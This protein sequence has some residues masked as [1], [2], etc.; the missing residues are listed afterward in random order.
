MTSE[1]TATSDG[2]HKQGQKLSA[3]GV[4]A[5]YSDVLYDGHDLSSR[6]IEMR[7]GT[8]I[9]I[10][11]IRPTLNGALVQDP[12]PVVWMHMT[13]NR[14]HFEGGLTGRTYPGAAMALVKYG[15]VVAIADMRGCYASH[16]HAVTPKRA[17]WQPDAFY[18]AYDITE[19]LAAQPWSTGKIGMWG[20]SATGHS[21]WQAAAS[22]PPH[23]AAIMPLS[24]PS[25]YYD[26]NGVT[27]TEPQDP[28]AYPAAEPPAADAGAVPVDE[29][30]DGA[31]LAQAREAHRWNLEPGVMPFRDSV[32]PWLETLAGRKG[33]QNHLLVNTFTHFPQI[34]ASG[35]P[36]YQTA[37][38]GE[39]YR[40]KTGVAIKANSLSNPSKTAF[41]PGAH[42]LFSNDYRAEPTNG[43]N[44]N[45]E[46]RRWFDYWLKGIENGIMDEPPIYYFVAQARSE[47]EAWRFASTWP[48]PGTQAVPFYCQPD[49]GLTTADPAAQTGGFDYTVDYTVGPDDREDKGICFTSEAL[50]AD[51][52]VIGNPVVHLWVT[53]S[54][55]DLDVTGYIYDV[56]PDGTSMQIPGTEDGRIRASLRKL[57]EPP[58][59]NAG[60]PYH[61]C[62]A[63]DYEPLTPGEPAELVFDLAPLAYNFCA[64]HR[65]RLV[66]TCVAIPRPG[67]ARITPV[68]SPAPQV[69]VLCDA[70]HPSRILLPMQGAVT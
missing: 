51:T 25:E 5:G 6:Y 1:Q 7:D 9:A 35:I 8:L 36:F 37:N 15:Y 63:E 62:F 26:I 10:D 11:I 69:R 49:G 59:D 24:A 23:L 56:S 13:Y 67:A 45:T 60:L 20:C 16:G 2:A 44:I 57:N 32:S 22:K 54:A 48:V 53:C 21:Q 50:G 65:I 43:L 39:D 64:G 33:V 29:D 34:E 38:W 18:D 52:E 19:W 46:G 12:L 3:P 27:A 31:L 68:L 14:R 61:R 4:Y 17:A 30:T 70:D 41:V 47:E 40:A 58:F 55:S 42:C 66:L 28:P